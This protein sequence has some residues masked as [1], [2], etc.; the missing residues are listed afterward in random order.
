MQFANRDGGEGSDKTRVGAYR[1]SPILLLVGFSLF[2]FA[3]V[4]L[5][6][7]EK[8][9]WYDELVT[10]YLCRLPALQDIH[11]AVLHATD[12]NPPLFYVITRSV[13]SLFGEGLIATRIPEILGFWVLCISLFLFVNRRAGMLA[14]FIAMV[15]PML[16][17]AYYYAYEARPHGIV[18]GCAGLALVC[19]QMHLEKRRRRFWLVCF[20]S[21]LLAAFMNH[22]YAL[23]LVIPFSLA[24]LFRAI[25]RK[26]I[27]WDVWIA[28]GVPAL[29][30][31]VVFVP[32]LRSYKA[33]VAGTQFGVTYFEP[34]WW[35]SL[36]FYMGLLSP[37][38][39]VVLVLFVLSALDRIGAIR[40]HDRLVGAGVAISQEEIILACSFLVL[41]FF[42]V[43]AGKI[44]HGPFIPRY[45]MSTVIGF[46]LL[47][48]LTAA[49]R[50]YGRRTPLILVAV[51]VSLLAKNSSALLW[52]RVHGKG[53]KLYEA[54]TGILLETTPG[55]PLKQFSL[56][57]KNAQG[58]RPVAILWTLDFLYLTY[59]AP[60]LL[61]HLYYVGCSEDPESIRAIHVVREWTRGNYNRENTCGEF[62]ASHPDFLVYGYL[63]G[64]PLKMIQ[65]GAGVRTTK[66]DVHSGKFIS[67]M[68]GNETA[69]ARERALPVVKL[70]V[71]Q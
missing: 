4:L 29:I 26:R 12:F 48:S 27:W 38:L 9:F 36:G 47:T 23:I 45:F 14:G 60:N 11:Q 18:L 44:I 65:L 19:W 16:T 63:G 7:S 46:C 8:Y 15:L 53:E 13:Q 70:N 30:A 71:E 52:H 21:C 17:Q 42:G 24:E 6:A 50:G 68:T 62:I 54:G 35:G 31:C 69:L 37:C 57:V 33:G 40:A 3:D 2:Y 5:R 22:C 59:Y 20:S 25:H 32:L 56:L 39:L 28:L 51:I 64:E 43:L 58:T 49:A 41:P 10:V 34:S 61:P 1:Y 67:E 55:Q 66:V